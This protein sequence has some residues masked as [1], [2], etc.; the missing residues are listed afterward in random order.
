MAK[1][2]KN[3]TN[4]ELQLGGQ[5]F[6]VAAKAKNGRK[7]DRANLQADRFA[8]TQKPTPLTALLVCGVGLYPIAIGMKILPIPAHSLHAPYW[9]M[10]AIG[11]A[12]LFAGIAIGLQCLGQVKTIVYK[13]VVAIILIAMLTPF[14]W[15]VFGDSQ[16]NM[17]FRIAFA[18]PFA[19]IFLLL[20]PGG[21]TRIIANPE[22]KPLSE[23]LKERR[24]EKSRT[25]L[26]GNKEPINAAPAVVNSETTDDTQSSTKIGTSD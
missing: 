20:L 7:D 15:L 19:I 4:N 21:K 12:V 23:L 9:V 25:L 11:I 1:R 17:F 6:Q 16:L 8:N 22:G 14:A 5:D 26:P 18:S 24:N 13:I 10:T 2:R 3:N